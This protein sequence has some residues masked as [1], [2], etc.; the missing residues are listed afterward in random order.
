MLY[1]F[2]FVLPLLHS[3]QSPL[4][5]N[6]SLS[7]LNL[8]YLLPPFCSDPCHPLVGFR[9]YDFSWTHLHQTF[10]NVGLPFCLPL[11]TTF[12][13][14]LISFPRPPFPFLVNLVG[15]NFLFGVRQA[16]PLQIPSLRRT[17]S[18]QFALPKAF[19]L[20]GSGKPSAC[21]ASPSNGPTC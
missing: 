21:Q 6:R 8:S 5:L 14:T 1:F 4:F 20:I 9:C 3:S 2:V 15:A 19:L 10:R 18:W 7:A 16:D 13:R 11:S 12:P 17:P